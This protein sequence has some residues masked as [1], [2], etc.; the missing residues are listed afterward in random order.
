MHPAAGRDEEVSLSKAFN[1][2]LEGLK[3]QVNLYSYL[4]IKGTELIYFRIKEDL[5]TRERR[6]VRRKGKR[7]RV[8]LKERLLRE[9]SLKAKPVFNSLLGQINA[10]L[11]NI[12]E[13]LRSNGYRVKRCII[14]SRYRVVAGTGEPAGKIPF[15]VGVFLDPLLGIP[16][17]PGSSLKGAFRHALEELVQHGNIMPE[18][19]DE[20]LPSL[21]FGSEGAMGLVGITDAY[22]IRHDRE[23]LLEPDVI[24]PHYPGA[25]DELEA[26]PNPITFLSI[27]PGVEFE[28]YIYYKPEVSK[29]TLEGDLASIAAREGTQRVLEMLKPLDMAVLYALSR[30]VGAKTSAGY[31]RFDL[32]AYRDA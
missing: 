26:Q 10:Y 28:F 18:L 24:T 30:G 6:D 5:E 16:Y 11:D 15:E 12:R 23:R 7:E 27:A 31:S 25:R 8:E 1:I 2:S 20:R 13:A 19:K 14:K 22:P 29:Y 17:I 21:L 4:M 3:D 9:V 32:V